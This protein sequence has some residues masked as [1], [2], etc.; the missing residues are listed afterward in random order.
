MRTNTRKHADSVL[1]TVFIACLSLPIADKLIGLDPAKPRVENRRLADL[2]TIR[3]SREALMNLPT[4]YKRY[5]E[6]RFGFRNSLIRW[7]GVMNAQWMGVSPNSR[8]LLGKEGWLFLTDEGVVDDHRGANPLSQE[9]L[10]Q[11]LET[12]EARS[13]WLASKGIRFMIVFVP[14][15]HTIYHEYLPDSVN[16]VG[17]ST[18]LDQLVGYLRAHSGVPIVDTRPA[19]LAQKHRYR[20]YQ[21]TDTHWNE[22]GA[23]FAYRPI[24]PVLNRWFDT[25]PAP[26]LT[27][28]TLTPVESVGGDLAGII[29]LRD[30]MPDTWLFLHAYSPQEVQEKIHIK[31][32]E[33]IVTEKP[34]KSLPRG[35]IFRDS[36]AEALRPFF[37]RHFSRVVYSSRHTFDLEL[38]EREDPDIVIHEILERILMRPP[39]RPEKGIEDQALSARTSRVVSP[40]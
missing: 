25:G 22:V 28:L 32:P 13:A 23:Y 24:V 27:D 8:V 31:M 1:I 36:F 6:D 16:R 10:D 26:D 5:L 37:A 30:A 19:L 35:V 39:P 9:D 7:H 18:R 12:V 11:W 4:A 15:K 21:Q 17:D 38:I 34:D 2:P 29:G 3:L 14:N 20:L 33:T 40:E